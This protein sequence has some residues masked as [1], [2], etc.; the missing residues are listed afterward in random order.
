MIPELRKRFN[1]HWRPELYS[2]FLR[3]ANEAVGTPIEFRLNETPVF[4]PRPLLDKMIR[5][6][7]ELYEQLANNYEYRRV[8][9]AAVPSNFY[10]P[11][12]DRHPLFMQVDFGLIQQSDGTLQPRLVEIQGFPSVYGFQAA[13]ADAYAETYG[14]EEITGCRLTPFL[15]GLEHN[16]YRA[17]LSKAIVGNHAPE[18]VVLLEIDPYSQKTLPD[19]LV[20]QRWLGIRIAC[21]S[22]VEKRGRKL[23]LDDIP[24]ERMYNRVIFDE[25]V[26]RDIEYK[27][28]FTDDLDVEWAGHPNWFFRLS[29]FSLPWFHHPS[30]PETR[31]LSDV[32]DLPDHPDDYVLKPLYSFAGLGVK[33][34][35]TKQELEEIPASERHSFVLQRRMEFVPT[36]ET[37][38]GMTKVEV[39]IMYIRD[40]DL[41][42]PVTT[43]IRTGRGKMMGVDFNK[44]LDWV[45]ASA[46]F[47]V[48]G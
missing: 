28:A 40:D 14:L 8:S 6:G 9:D 26:R 44:N 3:R 12:E 10:V 47:S 13:I 4:L 23:F 17:L 25:L 32:R 37:P 34:G 29:K 7:I 1:A 15:G 21:I 18:N 19:F 11:N 35:P 46:G 36:L 22:Q 42:K 16:S 39:R 20:T 33:I 45:G 38:M 31:F 24:I 41:F 43:V 30:V 5:Y 27:F 48:T 2:R